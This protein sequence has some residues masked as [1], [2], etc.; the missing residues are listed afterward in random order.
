LN[1]SSSTAEDERPGTS[2]K[3]TLKRLEKSAKERR[4]LPSEFF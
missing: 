2:L 4:Y 1:V 3:R